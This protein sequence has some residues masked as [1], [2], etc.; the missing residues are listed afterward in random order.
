MKQ[1]YVKLTL[2]R[3]KYYL[4]RN[5]L[6]LKYDFYFKWMSTWLNINKKGTPNIIIISK[7]MENGP[8][9]L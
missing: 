8:S 9:S 3:K 7:T 1:E 2:K 5:V 4:L 6:N